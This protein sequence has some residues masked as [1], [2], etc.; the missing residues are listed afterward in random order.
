MSK[1]DDPVFGQVDIR[2]QCMRTNVDSMRERAHR[3]LGEFGLVTP[4][5]DG[6]GKRRWTI[7]RICLFF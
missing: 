2:L 5:R 1:H 7:T 6:L 4:V 3:V